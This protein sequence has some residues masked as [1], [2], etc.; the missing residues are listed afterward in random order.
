MN[1][2]SRSA[3]IDAPGSTK[4]RKHPVVAGNARGETLLTW[5]EGTGW[6]KGGSVAWQFYDSAGKPLKNATG[7]ADSLP[8]WGWVTAAARPNGD[9]V[10]M[11]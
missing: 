6:N 1:D 8:V 11:W 2:G 9:F 10:V 4:N 3:T 5:A 7:H